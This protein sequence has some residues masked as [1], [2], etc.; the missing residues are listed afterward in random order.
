MASSATHA[1]DFIKYRMIQNN[2]TNYFFVN[3]GRKKDVER[4][5]DEKSSPGHVGNIREVAHFTTLDQKFP[6]CGARGTSEGYAQV[7]LGMAEN[8]NILQNF[9]FPSSY[10]KCTSPQDN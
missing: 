8:T 6:T 5:E 3:D 10:E 2:C 9:V 1:L 4:K 7:I